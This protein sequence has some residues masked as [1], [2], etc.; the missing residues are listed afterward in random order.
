LNNLDL[1]TCFRL[2]GLVPDAAEGELIA[3]YRFEPACSPH[4]AAEQAGEPIEFN[5]ILRSAEELMRRH[6]AVLVEGAGGVLVPINRRQTML[7][8][9]VAL[10]L[11]VILA[12]RP[13]LG[14]INHTLLSIRELRSAGLA[15]RGVVFCETQAAERGMIER[16]NWTTIEELANVTILG[17]VPYLPELAAGAITPERFAAA[18]AKTL[19]LN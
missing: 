17:R 10:Q 4:L 3:P 12:S 11:P 5:R 14:T 1:D 8:L 19:P 18:V 7:D 16:D 2:T 9:M 13:G 15:V 6:Q